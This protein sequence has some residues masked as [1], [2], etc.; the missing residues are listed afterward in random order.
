MNEAYRYSFDTK[1]P[2]QEAIESLY[3]AIFAAEGVHGRAQVRLDAGY[4]FDKEGRSLAI[5]AGTPVGKTV[6]QIFTS[7]LTRQFGEDAFRVEH[8]VATPVETGHAQ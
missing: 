2:L 5:D 1:V 8:V 6:S 4:A 7:L 3:L